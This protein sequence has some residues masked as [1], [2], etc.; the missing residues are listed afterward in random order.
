[1]PD[2]PLH[3]D[4]LGGERR[5]RTDL[6]A[7]LDSLSALELAELLGELPSSRQ[8]PLRLGVVMVALNER[9]PD[10]YKLLPPAGQ[11]GPHEGRRRSLREPVADR[12]AARAA[13]R[14]GPPPLGLAEWQAD[15]QRQAEQHADRRHAGAV[16]E[17]RVAEALRAGASDPNPAA[18]HQERSEPPGRQREERDSDREDR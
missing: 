18:G 7:Y 13:H 11:P 12:C 16:A 17:R 4:Q 10:A 2:N 15:R 8:E 9:L 1:M 14:I 3:P 6:V 5:F